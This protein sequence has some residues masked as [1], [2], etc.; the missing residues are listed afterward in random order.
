MQIDNNDFYKEAT[1]RLL[2][3]LDIDAAVRNCFDY[4]KRFIPMDLI[5]LFY[6]DSD[7]GRFEILTVVIEEGGTQIDGNDAR[8]DPLMDEIM[9]H[10]KTMPAVEIV[11]RPAENRYY[12][13]LLKDEDL[14]SSWLNMRLQLGGTRIGGLA[15]R[16]PGN[17]KFTDLH[18]ELL[19]MLHEPFTFA[20]SNALKHQQV[21][22]LKDMLADDNRYLH[23]QLQEISGTEIVGADFGLKR[24]LE[25]V[26]QV[27]HVDCPV[28]L[29]G[30]TGTGKD[31]I[32]NVLHSLSP[33]KEGPFIRVNC[34]AI[35]DSLID[36]ELFGHEKGAFTGAVSQ[37]RGLFERA[38]G[39]TIFLD[40][41]GELP[42]Q[43]QVRLLHVIQNGE[44]E[45]VGGTAPVSVNLRIISATH[46][47]LQDM[48][49]AGQFREDL[50]FRLNVFPITIP[51]LRLRKE[52][53]PALVHH[54][55]EKKRI[56]LKLPTKP[57][58]APNAINF[59]MD[60]NWPGNVRELENVVERALIQ[61]RDGKV[62]FNNQIRNT[63]VKDS[64]VEGIQPE[65]TKLEDV[66]SR[67]I[68]QIMKVSNGKINGPGGAGEI[69][70]VHP[71]TLRKRMDKL[72]IPYGKKG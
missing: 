8:M 28:L 70:G 57:T 69:L 14:N 32:A 9:E 42:P 49:T 19:Q 44:F 35:P 63:S 37:K 17:N 11:N 6:L 26:Q 43:A 13:K 45:R 54:F 59:L 12:P 29:L 15:I 31:I 38:D 47:K 36:S 50:W 51:P 53:I 21:L 23:N 65:A 61:C 33:R 46:R 2:G 3:S 72:G 5:S 41:V 1:T 60:Y 71:N 40:E 67:H 30:E 58:L 25:Q 24:V 20:M 10:W 22:R 48:V 52:D 4:I 56:T 62:D 18:K 68:R 34:G 16:E 64:P 55:I 27:T 7:N 66:I 39:G